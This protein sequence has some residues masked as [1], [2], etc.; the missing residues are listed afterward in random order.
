[1]TLTQLFT[2]IANKI[3]EIKG[4]SAPIVA[5]NF[6][7][8]MDGMVVPTGTLSITENGT[9]DVTNYANANVEV[10]GGGIDTSDATA[11]ANDIVTGKTAYVDG[12]KLTGTYT[13]IIPIGTIPITQNGTVDV[14][15]YANA[16]VN[17]PAPAPNLQSKDITIT[18]NGTQTVTADSGYDGLNEVEIITNVS[19]GGGG[20][21]IQYNNNDC[22][23]D[24]GSLSPSGSKI[25]V[26]KSGT[27]TIKYTAGKDST[28]GTYT[29]ALYKNGTQIQST[30]SSTW[31][32]TAIRNLQEWTN[33]MIQI[34]VHTGIQLSENDEIEVYVKSR[35]SG[36]W[37]HVYYLLI[38]EE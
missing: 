21:N 9:I 18:T 14:T 28:S 6:P 2:N 37:V 34:Q 23:R 32:A 36:Y 10:S 20:K 27:Y 11:T 7:D 31:G 24:T 1:M 25:T 16:N 35:T 5:E 4:T 33:A 19:G 8:E 29:T 3:R 26:K 30:V 38:E 17:V 22:Y 15:N 13:G 12:Q